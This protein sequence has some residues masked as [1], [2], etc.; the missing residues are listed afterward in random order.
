MAKEGGY[1]IRCRRIRIDQARLDPTF[2]C[3]LDRA[4][5]VYRHIY[6][7]TVEHEKDE[8]STASALMSRVR[9]EL[10]AKKRDGTDNP[11]YHAWY[12]A[13][14]S[15]GRQKAV[16]HYYEAKKAGKLILCV[17]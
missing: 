13:L 5:G 14:P 10:T 6:N 3:H 8:S 17:G 11:L 4:F 1:V 16:E 2:R 7:A 15:L 9:S 12:D